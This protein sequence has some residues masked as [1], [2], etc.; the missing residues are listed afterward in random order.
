MREALSILF[1]IV[2]SKCLSNVE[3]K[4]AGVIALNLTTDGT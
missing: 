4:L 2:D 1:F 3:Q